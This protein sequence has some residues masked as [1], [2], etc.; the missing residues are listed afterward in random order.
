MS[1][2]EK[3]LLIEEKI[4]KYENTVEEVDITVHNFEKGQLYKEYK[5]KVIHFK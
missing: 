1:L 2:E 3:L 4:K 5:M